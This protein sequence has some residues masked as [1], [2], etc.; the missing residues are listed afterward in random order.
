MEFVVDLWL[1]LWLLLSLFGCVFRR[2]NG[3]AGE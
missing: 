2:H 1:Y 3:S